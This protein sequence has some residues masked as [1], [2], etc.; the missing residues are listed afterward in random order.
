M[1]YELGLYSFDRQEGELAGD[2]VQAGLLVR[3]RL[4]SEDRG[5]LAEGSARGFP[6]SDVYPATSR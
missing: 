5:H 6:R 1:E 3:I 2:C 4:L